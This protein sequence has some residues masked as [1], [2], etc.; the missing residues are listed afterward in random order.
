MPSFA[1]RDEIFS[2]RLIFQ[3]ILGAPIISGASGPHNWVLRT[4][5]KHL[6]GALHQAGKA[7][8]PAQGRGDSLGAR[9]KLLQMIEELY[10]AAASFPNI[11]YRDEHAVYA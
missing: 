7:V 11:E 8:V 1:E 4:L 10:D 6:I 9:R 2:F 3:V 5:I